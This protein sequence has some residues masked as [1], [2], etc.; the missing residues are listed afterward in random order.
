MPH[1]YRC[2][3]RWADMDLLGHVN[4]VTYLDY[5]S[6]ARAAAFAGHPL[7]WASVLRHQV[8]FVRPLVF[9]R[10]PVLVDT[11]VTDEG[12]GRV[13]LAH[14]VYDEP[15]DPGG[16]R[17]V[18]LRTATVLAHHL[19]DEE[20]VL[21]EAL[22]G[23]AL[24]WRAVSDDPRP[25]GDTFELV[26]RRSDVDERGHARDGVF[27]EYVQE[28]RINYLMNLHSRGDPWSAVVV[29][30]TDIDYLAP[31]TYRQE[32]YLV[33]SWVAHLGTR[34]FTV[35][36]EVL[37]GAQS[38]ASSAVVMVTYDLETQ[39]SAEMSARQR[40]RLTE[41]LARTSRGC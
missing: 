21:V 7:A 15:A 36:S 2:P 14:E 19:T 17:Q 34:S 12:D 31:L 11:W 5:V 16:V 30:R 32:P 41:E 9:R 35:R 1:T 29:A 24:Q 38:L 20:R 4:N 37:D 3:M 28:A 23:P 22:R 40:E 10:S 8:E 18:Y 33:R 13:A 27:L 6:E 25:R 39:A 26:P